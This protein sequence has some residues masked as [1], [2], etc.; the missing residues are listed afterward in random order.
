M[1]SDQGALIGNNG[2]IHV[3]SAQAYAFGPAG[4]PSFTIS[5]L[6]TTTAGGT[7]LSWNGP[8]SG[9]GGM[10][11]WI[12][13]I[14]SNGQLRFSNAQDQDGNW[15][16]YQGTSASLLDGL[17][18]QLVVVCSNGS[19]SM[20]IDGTSIAVGAPA[21]KFIA[22]NPALMP[23]LSMGR[24]V[25]PNQDF[26]QFT[27]TLEDTTLFQ[28][29]L[30]A[31]EITACR[32]NLVTGTEPDLIGLWRMN[33][34][35][36]DDL[37]L[38]N[39]GQIAGSVSFIPV[40]HTVWANGANAFAFVSMETRYG[41]PDYG[42]HTQQRAQAVAF[43]DPVSRKENLVVPAGASYLAFLIYGQD[44]TFAYPSGVQCVIT[45]PDGTTIT[46]NSNTSTAY[47][48]MYQ[49]SPWQVLLANPA[50]GTWKLSVT[51][52]AASEFTLGFQTFP[53]SNIRQTIETTL[54]PCYP[55]N[56]GGAA[57]F[58]SQSDFLFATGAGIVTAIAA[59]SVM[60]T[61]SRSRVEA[62]AAVFIA[63]LL[64]G[65]A[66]ALIAGVA[67]VVV[68]VYMVSQDDAK[69]SPDLAPRQINQI[70]QAGSRKPLVEVRKALVDK[71]GTPATTD[72]TKFASRADLGVDSRYMLTFD[73]GGEGRHTVNGI[74]SGFADAIN[75]NDHTNDSTHPNVAIPNLV[76]MAA[77]SGN[78]QY[79][80][81]T[82]TANYVVMQDAPLND[83]N[84]KEIA[85]LLAPGGQAG[86]W[87]DQTL[88]GE[89]VKA[90]AKTLQTVPSYSNVNPSAC[91][92]EF[93]G[94]LKFPKICL[95]NESTGRVIFYATDFT[96]M[97]PAIEAARQGYVTHVLIG[98]F[99]LGYDN[100]GSKTGPY[101]HLNNLNVTDPS[102]DQLW[103]DVA[104]LQGT[105][106]RVLASL[107]GGGVGD[108]GNLFASNATY[109]TFYA[110]LKTALQ[111]KNLDGIDLDIEES[112]AVVSTA[113][114]TKLITSLRND[115]SSR[116]RGFLVTSAPVPS[117]LTGGANISSNVNYNSLINS[118][119]FYILQFYNG[120]GNLNP[121]SSNLPHYADVAAKFG[122][123]YP[124][125]L[126]AGVLTNSKDAGSPTNPVGYNTLSTIASFLPG[127]ISAYPNFG[128]VCGWTYQ[129]ALNLQG[130][131]KPLEWAQ[132]V[133]GLV[134][135]KA[136]AS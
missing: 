113:N 2:R 98:L 107:G 43:T 78:P 94:Q 37:P 114:V 117:A 61:G 109:D 16:S 79:P 39:N 15:R 93:N 50:A 133:A 64:I 1:Q 92:D 71:V 69:I 70:S 28:R 74:T 123:N 76:L 121:G 54:A 90:L 48:K 53:G 41:A 84:V 20:Q 66:I 10:A 128:G 75:F 108:F 18:H 58:T 52:P 122:V 83:R 80:V 26:P 126:V 22:A 40:F 51:G 46:A 97:S 103:R 59:A 77:F 30:T 35:L 89:Q 38:G 118:F 24:V 12:L 31:N 27:G 101:I 116:A 96:A 8:D 57:D 55:A 136:T 72:P 7:V 49:G 45:R 85:R 47:V 56:S 9:T 73:L 63:P 135:P 134:R 23:S 102:Y 34:N 115:F 29:A 68:D 62:P 42:P 105:G 124:R 112:A 129:N 4:A 36:K 131:I 127:I 13:A 3:P 130:V 25:I 87:I 95:R 67:K 32:F 6:V 11:G 132:T 44:G 110:L 5:V 120:F 81:T 86:L 82:G 19:L 125:K 99:H 65:A 14:D 17:W 106:V 111:Q 21:A 88:Y 119:D 104:T 91:G 33:G 100:E 60:G